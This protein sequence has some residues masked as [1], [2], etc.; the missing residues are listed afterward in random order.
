MNVVIG[1][2]VVQFLFW[3]YLFRVFGNVSLPQ[4]IL[5]PFNVSSCIYVN[6]YLIV[7]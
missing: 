1:T 2:V 5:I 6:I 7:E 3:E 4:L